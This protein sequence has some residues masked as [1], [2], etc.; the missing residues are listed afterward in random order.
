MR[1]V[2]ALV[3][4]L[5]PRLATAQIKVA[6]AGEHT[7][8]SVYIADQD[9][10]PAQLQ[11]LLGPGYQVMNFGY[12]RATVQTENI[13]FP[14]AQPLAQTMEF[15]ASLAFGPDIVVLGPFGRHDSA[16]DYANPAAID[17]AKFTAGLV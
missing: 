4:M 11:A 7:T 1:A 2:L 12:P 16:A 15:A 14:N 13:T 17:R 8:N 6:C 9:E 10:Y 3:L 5:T